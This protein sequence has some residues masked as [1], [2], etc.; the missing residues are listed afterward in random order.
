MPIEPE[1]TY[2]EL[3][4]YLQNIDTCFVIVEIN[5]PLRQDEIVAAL[6]ADLSGGNITTIDLKDTDNLTG[7]L[8]EI[9]TCIEKNPSVEIILILNLHNMKMGGGNDK[10]ALLTDL[11]L[12]RE[13]YLNL[14]KALV[15]FLPAYFTDLVIKIAKDFFAYVS[16]TFKFPVV[17]RQPLMEFATQSEYFNEQDVKNRILFLEHTLKTYSLT[18]KECGKTYHD[19]GENYKKIYELDKALENY[20]KSLKIRKEIGDKQGEGTTLGNIAINYHARGDYESALKYMLESL[21]TMKEIGHKK[22]EGTTLNNISQIYHAR[23]DYES[24]LKYMLES[25][26]IRKEIGDKEGEGVTLNNISSIYHA[27]G[28]YESA[29]KYL[30]ESLK[31]RKEIG[32]KAR[33]GVTLNNI[34]QIY[35]ARGDYES[36]LKY[37]L[38]SLK[39]RKEIGDKAG[40]GTTLGNIATNYHARGD[41]ESALKYM[42]ESLKISKEI[43]DKSGEAVTLFNLAVLYDVTGKKAESAQCLMKVIEIN[44]TLKSYEIAQALKREGIEG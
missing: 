22:G 11:N 8:D 13:L 38:E 3:L 16:I 42:L 30:I 20:Q 12:S 23:G 10:T 29:L 6:M 9:R 2:R 36:A 43:G 25:L 21:K 1:N 27:R 41:Y 35:H 15:F 24:A 31:I 18:E 17:H 33:E 44:K 5:E 39:I 28:D 14:N 40:E 34:S 26:K 4:L 7:C 19:L 32:D 37:M